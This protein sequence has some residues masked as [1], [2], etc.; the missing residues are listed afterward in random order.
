MPPDALA[1][2]SPA[3]LVGRIRAGESSAEDELVNR[4]RRGLA[5]ILARAT[6]D[7][8]TIDD[9]LQD[10][11]R[12][13]LEKIRKGDLREP[14]KLSGFL[15]GLARNLAIEHFRKAAARRAAT[16]AGGEAL[17]RTPP[18]PQELALQAERLAIVRRVLSELGSDRDR[19]ILYRFYIAEDE[20]DAICRDLRLSSLHFNR[21]LFRA[22]ERYRTLYLKR[23][24]THAREPR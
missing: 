8:P 24:E 11:F 22:R 23:T 16:S 14:E 15:S 10:A 21:V 9:L 6:S 5:F 18:D 20:K 4:Y 12:I 13:A 1:A 19:Q 7:R 2:E 17:T 3:G